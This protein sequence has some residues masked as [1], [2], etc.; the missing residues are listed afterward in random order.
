[1]LF[2]CSVEFTGESFHV[3]HSVTS[4]RCLS[5]A[6]I[7]AEPLTDHQTILGNAD[8]RLAGGFLEIHRLF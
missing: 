4:E 5:H 1:M 6:A 3:T 7:K 8:A 2:G